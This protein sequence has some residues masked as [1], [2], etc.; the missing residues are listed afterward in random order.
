MSK[1]MFHSK[2][3]CYYLLF[4]KESLEITAFIHVW[5]SLPGSAWFT[6]NDPFLGGS[7]S[8]HDV[9]GLV[10]LLFFPFLLQSLGPDHLYCRHHPVEQQNLPR[11]LMLSWGLLDGFSGH[12]PT[13]CPTVPI[14]KD[15]MFRKCQKWSFIWNKKTFPNNTYHVQQVASHTRNSARL[16]R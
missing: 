5:F 2:K 11:N 9:S 6:R 12:S 4:D 8:F 1:L 14:L 13:S 15:I 16:W 3:T 10:S 7:R